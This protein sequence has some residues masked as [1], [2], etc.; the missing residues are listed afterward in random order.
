MPDSM[1]GSEQKHS[2]GG[3]R[4]VAVW[5]WSS[6]VIA[7]AVLMTRRFSGEFQTPISIGLACCST[8]AVA[9][10]SWTAW[11]LLT[12]GR[13]V[14]SRAAT[15]PWVAPAISVGVTGAW[16]W[17]ILIGASPLA[18]GI[19]AGILILQTLAITIDDQQWLQ[20]L[21]TRRATR[22]PQQPTISMSSTFRPEVM[23]VR[24]ADVGIDSLPLDPPTV[25]SEV[26]EF[27]A[28]QCSDFDSE[29]ESDEN[30]T[31][32][33]SRRQSDNGE[34]IEGWVR[35]PF[36]SGQRETVI[37]VAFCPPL[38]HVPA[39]ETEDLDGVGLEIRVAAVFPFGARLS[40]RRSGPSEECQSDRV[41]FIA[42]SQPINH[43]A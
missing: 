11:F 40:V 3:R 37:H 14:H 34:Q 20:A 41:G 21:D 24:A 43:A 4:S 25:E 7:D 23:T 35:V 42:L 30:Q 27:S 8:L 1:R 26:L 10:A 6:L 9:V 19:L 38:A 12:G 16:G 33:L 29:A 28:G 36:A 2:S 13:G 17:S 5:I 31:L 32:W 15:H 39:V 18:G 22:G